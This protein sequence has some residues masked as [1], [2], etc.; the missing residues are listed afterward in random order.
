MD[1]HIQAAKALYH[2]QAFKYAIEK[3]KQD[4]I[5]E[6]LAAPSDEDCLRK[7]R[8]FDAITEVENQLRMWA[9]KPE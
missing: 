7:R 3:V 2:S 1:D 4:K 8:Q 9:G 5:E 6:I